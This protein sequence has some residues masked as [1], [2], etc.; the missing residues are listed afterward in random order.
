MCD[1]VGVLLAITTKKPSAKM[2]ATPSLSLSFIWS[3]ETIVMGR[4]IMV[5][6]VKMLT[7]SKRVSSSMYAERMRCIDLQNVVIQ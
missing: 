3:R 2:A 7:V 1:V 4:R 5:M 6:S